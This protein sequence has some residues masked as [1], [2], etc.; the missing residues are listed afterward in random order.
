MQSSELADRVYSILKERALI[1]QPIF[2][3]ELYKMVGLDHGKVVDRSKG[4]ELLESANIISG[5]DY[6]ISSFAVS[7]E[8]NGPYHGFYVL[9]EKWGRIKH[10]LTEQE[11]MV[12]WVEEMKRVH[13]K[14]NKL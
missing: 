14:C 11:K 4:S 10:G 7:K 1:N 12:F 8:A 13:K 3:G 2:Y 6:M 9:A 5:E